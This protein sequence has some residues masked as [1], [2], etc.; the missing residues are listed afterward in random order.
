MGKDAKKKK[1]AGNKKAERPADKMM[2]PA[3]NKSAEADEEEIN[4]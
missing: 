1:T 3:E 4:G 2:R